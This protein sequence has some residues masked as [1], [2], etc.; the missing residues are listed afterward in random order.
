M[1]DF[2]GGDDDFFCPDNDGMNND[3]SCGTGDGAP[4]AD[5]S[6]IEVGFECE[7]D[8]ELDIVVERMDGYLPFQ[9]EL[10]TNRYYLT[11]NLDGSVTNS[12]GQIICYVDPSEIGSICS[13]DCRII[14][15]LKKIK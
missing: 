10:E 4:D 6:F 2:F 5:S 11:V 15:G 13:D 12:V 8:K 3:D 1:D 14:E 7:P 9:Q